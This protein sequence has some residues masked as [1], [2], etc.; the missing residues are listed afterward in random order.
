[1]QCDEIT[2]SGC[3]TPTVADLIVTKD[4]TPT[5]T[6]D[7]DWSVAKSQTTSSTPIDS[8]ASSVTVNYRVQ[9]TWSGP[10]DSGWQVGGTITVFNPNGTDFSGVTVSDAVD[11]GGTCVVTGGTNATIVANTSQDFSY[12]CSYSSA[13]SPLSGTNTATA[14]WDQNLYQ[15]PDASADF[16]L[17]FAF[18]D[19]AAGNPTI[20]H[21]TTTVSDTFNG[22]APQT[23]RVAGIAPP[24]ATDGSNHLT[25]FAE[26][27]DPGTQTFTLTYSRSVTVVPNTCTTYANTANVS[28]DATAADNSS[29][30]SV[31]VCGRVPGGLTMGFWQN[32]NGQG[33]IQN[34][35]GSSC[36]G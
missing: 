1:M 20:T 30:A 7:Y 17:P 26:S 31:T 16:L 14:A 5:F 15:T 6:R 28:G 29:S 12:T 24:W 35:S 23:P 36:Q 11:N 4:A 21:D 2:K 9:A 34:Y 13:P 32:K 19:G 27:Y 18:D 33:I 22:G 10:T 8:G 25:S 3:Q